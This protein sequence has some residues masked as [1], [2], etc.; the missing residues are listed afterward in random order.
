[1]DRGQ[2]FNEG[3]LS[4]DENNWQRIYLQNYIMLDLN[5]TKKYKKYNIMD[6]VV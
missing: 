6:Y 1:M 2:N 5:K 3:M 4:N